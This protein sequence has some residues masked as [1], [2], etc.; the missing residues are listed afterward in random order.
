MPEKKKKIKEDVRR[1]TGLH[2]AGISLGLAEMGMFQGRFVGGMHFPPGPDI[3]MNTA[4]LKV[5]LE[6]QP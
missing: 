2:R 6:E 4:P 1:T 5:I 3:V